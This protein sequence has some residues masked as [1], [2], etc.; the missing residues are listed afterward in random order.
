MPRSK[1][2]LTTRHG[3]SSLAPSAPSAM[4]S[5]EPLTPSPL[6]LFG[7]RAAVPALGSIRIR[8]HGDHANGT[9]NDADHNTAGRTTQATR[10]TRATRSAIR[11]LGPCRTRHRRRT[12]ARI[13][14]LG[15]DDPDRRRRT[16]SRSASVLLAPVFGQQF[17]VMH[18]GRPEFHGER[19]LLRRGR[20]PPF[21]ALPRTSEV[22][23][24]QFRMT[25]TKDVPTSKIL[26]R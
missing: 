26:P 15:A 10:A 14:H 9:A 21:A 25:L 1:N 20:H 8:C 3:P 22:P 17:D 5:G 23:I 2:T 7:V 6:V 12:G 4:D 18:A 13:P 19:R 24:A 16:E 11:L